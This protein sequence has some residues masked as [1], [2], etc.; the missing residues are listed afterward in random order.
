VSGNS[1]YWLNMAD[2]KIRHVSRMLY[3]RCQCRGFKGEC[4]YGLEMHH[5]ISCGVMHFRHDLR[6][7]IVLCANHHRLSTLLSPHGNPK[8]F[9]EW[10][11]K[12][13]RDHWAWVEANKWKG[14]KKNYKEAYD[15]L[16]GFEELL[17][18]GMRPERILVAIFKKEEVED[19]G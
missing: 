10:M 2:M 9:N 1:N 7:I 3:P 4:K 8:A 5:M 14:G 15:R 18:N 6:N 13:R 11:D 12:E 17:K 16:V 19:E